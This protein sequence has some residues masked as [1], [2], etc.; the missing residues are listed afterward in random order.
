MKC[1]VT[2]ENEFNYLFDET[3]RYFE[4]SCIDILVNN[5]GIGMNFGWKKCLEVNLIGMMQGCEI[6][7]ERMKKS[8]NPGDIK[9]VINISSMSG[10]IARGGEN[11]MGYTVSKHGSIA[12][13]KTLAAYMFSHFTIG[14]FVCQNFRCF[15]V[16]TI[17]FYL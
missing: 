13:T 4:C 12:L 5:A 8:S 16:L 17:V 7:M 9:T 2:K 11:V 1:D 3:E 14:T 15:P 6:A 10:I